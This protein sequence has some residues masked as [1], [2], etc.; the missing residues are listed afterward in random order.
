MFK[1]AL[2]GFG[3][4]FS[5]LFAILQIGYKFQLYYIEQQQLFLFGKEHLLNALK[6]VGGLSI[7][8]SHYC[9]QFFAIPYMGSLISASILAF[10]AFLLH[11][12]FKSYARKT[13]NQ[14]FFEV[15]IVAALLIC[16]LDFNYLFSGTISFLLLSILLFIYSGIHKFNHRLFSNLVFAAILYWTAQ[17]INILFVICALVLDLKRYG[18]RYGLPFIPLIA[19]IIGYSFYQAEGYVILSRLTY[20]PARYYYPDLMPNVVIYAPWVLL[21]I[22][23]LT[24]KYLAILL[25]RLFKHEYIQFTTQIVC[26]F[27]IVFFALKQ[28]DDRKSYLFKELDFYARNEEWQKIIDCF[29]NQK[30]N[31]LLYLNYLNMALAQEE[32]LVD[33]MFNYNQKGAAGL[34]VRWNNT[35]SISSILSDIYYNVGNI[36]LARR[37]AF[38]SNVC[39]PYNGNPRS[40]KR[41]VETNIIYGDYKIAEKYISYL[42]QSFMYSDWAKEKRELIYKPDS[43]ESIP[44]YAAKRKDLKCKPHFTAAETLDRDLIYIINANK[45]N[46]PAEQYLFA[47]L[48]LNKNIPGFIEELQKIHPGAKLQTKGRNRKKEAIGEK[49]KLRP[50]YEQVVIAYAQQNPDIIKQYDISTASIDLFKAYNTTLEQHAQATNLKDIMQNQFGNTYWFYHQF[51]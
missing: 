15:L 18:I 16:Q 7:Y 4:L 34:C 19:S 49:T 43:I 47:S 10:T 37:F 40:L 33:S 50:I 5:I 44:E 12:I 6:T 35:Q 48:M 46:K 2:F 14:F 1:K 41:L 39:S 25:R 27:F 28:Y 36:A 23:L 13:S 8:L 17:P 51:K 11:F 31:N 29:D 21:I 42:E 30:I 20:T 26:I 38:E 9:L 32:I 3:I 24:N 22:G 45:D